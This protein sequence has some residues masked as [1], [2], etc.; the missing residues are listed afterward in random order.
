M[1]RSESMRDDYDDKANASEYYKTDRKIKIQREKDITI[2]EK[3]NNLS[4]DLRKPAS[5]IDRKKSKSSRFT[6][7]EGPTFIK[8]KRLFDLICDSGN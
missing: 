4:V 8:S 5:F 1:K 3:P 2:T 6:E 7:V